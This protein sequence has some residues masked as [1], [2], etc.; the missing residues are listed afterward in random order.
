MR[1]ER[2]PMQSEM[3][4]EYK[5]EKDYKRVLSLSQ[6]TEATMLGSDVFVLL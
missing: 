4:M 2:E 3:L 6:N 1:W 5:D